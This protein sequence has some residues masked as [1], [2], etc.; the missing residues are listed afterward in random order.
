MMLRERMIPCQSREAVVTV[1]SYQ[2]G[3]LDGYLQH[4]RLEKK[5]KLKSISQ[6]V[7]LLDGLLDLEGSLNSPLPLVLRECTELDGAA[8]FKIQILFREHYTWQGRLI[9]ENE[10]QEIV[11]HSAIELIQLLDEILSE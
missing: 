4:P 6:L 2:N 1:L 8:V 3:I 5:E 7:L 9:W 11:F 10:N